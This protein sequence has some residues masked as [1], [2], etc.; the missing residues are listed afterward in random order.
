MKTVRIANGQAFWGDRIDAPVK[1]V[2]NDHFDYLTLDYL[3]ELTMSI[4]KKQQLKNAKEGYARDFVQLLKEIL[5]ICLEKNIKIVTNA[6]G[7]NPESC[8]DEIF[9]ISKELGLK[10]Y[11]IGIVTGDDILDNVK[12]LYGESDINFTN[13]ETSENFSEISE[14]VVSANAYFGAFEIANALEQGAHIVITGRCTDPSLT[15]GPLIYEFQ[16]GRED[17][18]LLAAGTVA[19][20][21]IE[22]GAQVSGGNFQGGWE[23]V[24]DLA[25]IGYPIVEVNEQGEFWVTKQSNSGGLVNRATVTEQLLYEIG[26][27]QNYLSPDVIVDF[28]DI[29]LIEEHENVVRVVGCKGRKPTDFLKVSM[30]YED[31]FITQGLLSYGWPKALKKAKTAEQIL[32]KRME[33]FQLEFDEVLIEYIGF[34]GVHGPLSPQL[35]REPVECVLRAAVKGKNKAHHLRFGMELAQLIIGP[36]GLTGF[37]GGRPK[38]SQVIAYWPALIPKENVKIHVSV[39]AIH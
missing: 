19:G 13:L 31:G 9:A 30:S 15:L 32:R 21:L 16:W 7:I 22:C 6:G 5:P 17:Y 20:H 39:E 23:T 29:E 37:V 24:E 28:T 38:P 2:K 18:D 8:R 33:E 25:N 4:M 26:D 10:D 27:P 14:R 34:N 3:A 36:A 35:D 12:N 1:L 11:K